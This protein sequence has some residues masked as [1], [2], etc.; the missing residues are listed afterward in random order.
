MATQYLLTI[1]IGPV[2][3]FIA[4]ARRSRDLWFGSWVL[5]EI[6]KAAA[7]KIADACGLHNLIFPATDNLQDLEPVH[8]KGDGSYALVN[9]FNVVNKIVALIDRDPVVFCGDAQ[10]N[11][12]GIYDAMAK[13]LKKIRVDAYKRID[14]GLIDEVSAQ[15]QVEDLIEFYWAAYPIRDPNSADEYRQAREAVEALLAA[16]KNLRDFE[17]VSWA[18]KW[19]AGNRVPKSSL[20][21]QRESVIRDSV[22][23][24]QGAE[25]LSKE[26]L[27]EK[28][29]VREG[30]RLCGVG[31][32]K[33]HG[34]RA[35]DDS[36]FSTSHVAAGPLL[37]KLE[38]LEPVQKAKAK[39]AADGYIRHLAEL[40][41]ADD[42][43]RLNQLKGSQGALPHALKKELHKVIGFVPKRATKKEH[44][45]FGRWDGHLLY[46]ERL[47]EFFDYRT[48]EGQERL[49]EARE[50]LRLF[51]G[52]TLDG[53]NPK[54]YYA[55]LHADGDRMGEAIDAQPNLT[56]HRRLS[57]KLSEFAGSVHDI[58]ESEEHK[59]SLVYSGGDD[60]MAFLP[61]HT[62]LRCARELA[63]KF[64]SDMAEFS[65]ND[66]NGQQQQP[67]LSV[68]LA[69]GHHL[70]P[71]QDTL[72]LAREAEK[73]AKKLVTGK[74]AL[75]IIASR[76]SGADWT[77]KGSWNKKVQGGALDSRL[78]RLIC[79]QLDELLPRGVGYELRDLSL[80][81]R[82]INNKAP[83]RDE[84]IRILLRKRAGRGKKAIDPQTIEELG[85][86]LNVLDIGDFAYELIVSRLFAGA[87]KQA[88]IDAGR[89]AEFCKAA[90][91][92]EDAATEPKK[93]EA[94]S[95]GEAASS[96]QTNA[97]QQEG[98]V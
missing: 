79:L 66:G 97:Q 33:R 58:V 13:E 71:L 19:G 48:S 43:N 23:G 6:S 44:E 14:K 94:Q 37:E 76:R 39:E 49:K 89:Y 83:M 88:G 29:G 81:L 56:S 27:R 15:Q 24:P 57:K 96:N 42:A 52:Q 59:G 60:V 74:N 72:D 5:S 22:Y 9:E 46:K 87:V 18:I 70:D 92:Y 62:A 82:G 4:S 28:L 98:E 11:K 65:F 73:I 85:D 36:F 41:W 47:R 25:R 64:R 7:K 3:D 2:Q 1:A 54:P 77:V 80:R 68:G 61:L 31:L 95:L 63:D 91:N 12:D 86:W 17:P 55:L 35:G 40:L 50:A 10:I 26:A 90:T 93:T 45:V 8:Y 38:N 53:D 67:T 51:L 30:E 69:V 32:L 78:N 21:G 16:R 84:A 20:D 34:N 75:A